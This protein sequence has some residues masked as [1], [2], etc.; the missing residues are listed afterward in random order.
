MVSFRVTQG[1][2]H[3]G[4]ESFRFSVPEH[5]VVLAGSRYGTVDQ[6]T[7]RDLVEGLAG[8]DFSFL[9]G[10]AEGVDRSFRR[11]LA[12]AGMQERTF[13]ACAFRGRTG[14]SHS[15][16]LFSSVVV[17]RGL[18][19]RAALH[20]RTVWMVKRS[21]MAVVFPD[22]PSDGSW[23][24]GSQLVLRASLYHLHPVF[25]VS[26]KAPQE[27]IHYRVC[28][29]ELLGVVGGYWVVPH[30]IEDGGTCDELY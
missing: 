1:K 27:S 13:V 25:V 10:C 15:C 23:G 11:V 8:K 20:R 24:K 9:V 12:E 3:R 7:C 26:R 22:N 30:P 6:K 18:T 16:G 4:A 2:G 5:A 14:R 17:P 29:S 19:P 21:C 28:A